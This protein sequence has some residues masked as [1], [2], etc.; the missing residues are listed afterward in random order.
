MSD[1]APGRRSLAPFA[2]GPFFRGLI[3]LAR[4][5]LFAV[6]LLGLLTAA[7]QAFKPEAL[8][9]SADA[10][11]GSTRLA[12]GLIAAAAVAMLVLTV[13]AGYPL[14]RRLPMRT[15]LLLAAPIVLVGAAGLAVAFAAG[16]HLG[17]A[18]L[19]Y[20]LLPLVP[21]VLSLLLAW[22]SPPLPQRARRRRGGPPGP[23]DP[24][25]GAGS[26]PSGSSERARQRRG[27]RK[28]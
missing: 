13:V 18:A 23:V 8:A 17:S 25:P 12:M 24:R 5:A 15:A 19:G 22:G 3:G 7:R 14:N 26:P 11:A 16:S 4:L 10:A 20:L 28:R 2:G 27:G 6:V 1:R 21:F 9:R